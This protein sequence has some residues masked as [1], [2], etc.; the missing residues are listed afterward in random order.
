MSK[1][2]TKKRKSLP[3]SELALPK[4]RKYRVDTR[5]RAINAKAC[6]SQMEEEGKISK[7]TKKKIDLKANK[8]LK[9]ENKNESNNKIKNKNGI[10]A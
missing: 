9:K 3:S 5:N 6:A 7:S 10:E 4:E 8:K 2:T 1:L